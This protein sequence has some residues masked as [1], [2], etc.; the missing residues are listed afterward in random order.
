MMKKPIALF[1]LALCTFGSTAQAANH[2]DTFCTQLSSDIAAQSALFLK[3]A[4][5]GPELTDSM[6][7]APAAVLRRVHDKELVLHSIA[8]EIW[9]LRTR[10]ARHDCTQAKTFAY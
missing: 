2:G 5:T 3:V 10:M 4:G 8:N 1:C 6:P 7:S 9:S